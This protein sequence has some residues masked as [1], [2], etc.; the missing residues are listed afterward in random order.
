MLKDW[1]LELTAAHYRRQ[2][3]GQEAARDPKMVYNIVLSMPAPTPPERVLAASR[4]FARERF[5]GRHRYAM[6]LHTDQANPHV[7]MV[8]KAEDERGRRL[9]VN[10][11]MLRKWRD[12]FAQLMREQGIAAN[13][14]PR[15]VR[16][17][18]NIRTKDSVHRG[19]W[20]H[21]VDTVS[22]YKRLLPTEKERP[23]SASPDLA[24]KRI[25][26]RRESVMSYWRTAADI[27]DAQGETELAGA[28]R[29][30]AGRLPALG[31][32]EERRRVQPVRHDEPIRSTAGQARDHGDDLV[33]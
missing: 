26:T 5:G 23:R 30:F 32:D 6:V 27:L 18:E 31:S 24:N 21:D 7:H 14:T 19:R 4:K 9:H 13:A 11:A 29:Y 22:S 1:H 15:V 17:R 20:R 33:R 16:G 12:D 3:R 8:V 2:R 25:L 28:V 10:K